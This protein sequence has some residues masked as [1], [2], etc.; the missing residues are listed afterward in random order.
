MLEFAWGNV[1]E[2]KL[3]LVICVFLLVFIAV[4][5]FY[6][7]SLLLFGVALGVILASISWSLARRSQLSMDIYY[8]PNRL[9]PCAEKMEKG[10]K[11]P[12]CGTE[13]QKFGIRQSIG[14]LEEKHKTSG[15]TNRTRIKRKAAK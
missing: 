4:F 5:A 3:V 15:R 7:P 6:Y 14:L 8:C 11:C 10:K 13:A 12:M 2:G 1:L 9:C